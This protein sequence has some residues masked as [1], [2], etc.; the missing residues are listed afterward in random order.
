MA[1]LDHDFA[2]S[3]D[4]HG[5]FVETG[6]LLPQGH[7]FSAASKESLHWGVILKILEEDP[8]AKPFGTVN[9]TLKMLDTK[10]RT[11]EDFHAK[12]PGFGWFLPWFAIVNGTVAPSWDWHNHVP[13][14]DNG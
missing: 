13:S 8:R 4:G 6:E 1:G 3:Y 10:M 12:F 7:S 11:Y 2:V 9:Q 5:L 14:L